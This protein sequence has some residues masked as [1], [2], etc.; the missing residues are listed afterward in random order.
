MTTVN[1]TAVTNT[2]TVTEGD[3]GTT[4]VTV[5][6]TSTVTAITAGPQGPKGDTGA[7]GPQGL[8][9]D[10]GPQGPAGPAGATGPAGVVAAIAPL[11][12]NSGTQTVSTNMATGRLLGRT[13]AAAGVAE[14]ITVGSGLSLSAGTL[15]ATGGGSSTGDN[16]FLNVNC[17]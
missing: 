1:V 3:G 13:S 8:Q 9:G 4:V 5:P 14:E 16:L 2:V 6:V 10:P 17:I 15:S 11:T 7:T 12:Y